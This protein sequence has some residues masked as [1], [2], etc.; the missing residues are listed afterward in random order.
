MTVSG[1]D[2]GACLHLSISQQVQV[3]ALFERT[4]LIL[5]PAPIWLVADRVQALERTKIYQ[6]VNFAMYHEN[7]SEI[8]ALVN[9]LKSTTGQDWA[10]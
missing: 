9:G 8:F 6:I 3:G 1:F 2:A 5:Q 7:L 10:Q 4:C